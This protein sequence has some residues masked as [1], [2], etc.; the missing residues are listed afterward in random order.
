M[1]LA[2]AIEKRLESEIARALEINLPPPEVIAAEIVENL[3]AALKHFREVAIALGSK[4]A[5]EAQ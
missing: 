1:T 5:S 4:A 3:E 2:I